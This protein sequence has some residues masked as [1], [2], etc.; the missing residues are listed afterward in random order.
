MRRN[1][2]LMRKAKY[3]RANSLA[4]V[5]FLII[6]LL[7]FGAV[8]FQSSQRNTNSVTGSEHTFRARRACESGINI[9]ANLISDAVLAD[10]TVTE[11]GNAQGVM[12]FNDAA[13]PMTIE[14]GD[15]AIKKLGFAIEF[16]E[17]TAVGTAFPPRVEDIKSKA[18]GFFVTKS[19]R[20]A[21]DE[22]EVR[23]VGMWKGVIVR[24]RTVL[25]R[26]I[27][28]PF[29]LGGLHAVSLVKIVGDKGKVTWINSDDADDS[30]V[31][32]IINS[33]GDV[34]TE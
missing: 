7:G 5:L 27:G 1:I 17:L 4:L 28:R 33:D 3:P 29:Q 24:I 30:D 19:T 21:G 6:I 22:W 34:S 20:L 25:V 26:S 18:N 10:H 9:A 32:V 11:A 12:T 2:L 8:L 23:S 16:A 15:P 13:D 31:P 14:K